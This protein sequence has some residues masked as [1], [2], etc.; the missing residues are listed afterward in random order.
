MIKFNLTSNR[1]HW[2]YKP[3]NRV[4]W[5]KHIYVSFSGYHVS[6]ILRN[7]YSLNLIIKKQTKQYWGTFLQNNQL[8]EK[9]QSHKIQEKTEELS[10]IGDNGREMSNKCSMKFWLGSFSA[11]DQDNGW[12]LNETQEETLVISQC[13]FYSLV[14][15]LSY[16]EN[17]H[18]FKMCKENKS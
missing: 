2:N 14:V 6:S 8:I 15:R 12:N 9:C 4:E 13:E 5:Q 18:F 17:A 7:R 10:R 16:L 3:P 1:T 11:K